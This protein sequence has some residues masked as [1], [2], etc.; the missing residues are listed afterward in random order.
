MRGGYG[1]RVEKQ[2]RAN[3]LALLAL[4]LNPNLNPTFTP[5]PPFFPPRKPDQTGRNRIFGLFRSLQTGRNRP[6]VRFPRSFSV[7]R[8]VLNVGRLPSSILYARRVGTPCSAVRTP[9]PFRKAT[10]SD[11]RRLFGEIH[12]PKRDLFSL[13]NPFIGV[14]NRLYRQSNPTVRKTSAPPDQVQY[15][16]SDVRRIKTTSTRNTHHV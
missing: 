11:Q 1:N 13:F 14:K 6:A 3:R 5:R 7:E 8:S 4:N 16:G 10:L 15:V 9:P 12:S 2:C